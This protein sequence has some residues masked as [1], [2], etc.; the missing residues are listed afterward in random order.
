MNDTGYLMLLVSNLFA[1]SGKL[2]NN[3]VTNVGNVSADGEDTHMEKQI[4][5]PSLKEK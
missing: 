1:S 2:Y 3:V 4:V 5:R